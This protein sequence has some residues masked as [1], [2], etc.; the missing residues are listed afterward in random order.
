MDRSVSVS[1]WWL[2]CWLAR[3]IRAERA[4]SHVARGVTLGSRWL[5]LRGISCSLTRFLVNT[6][7]APWGW[8][9][10]SVQS[11]AG[12]SRIW[13]IKCDYSLEQVLM[14]LGPAPLVLHCTTSSAR[15][16]PQWNKQGRWKGFSASDLGTCAVCASRGLQVF[17]SGELYW[18]WKGGWGVEERCIVGWHAL[19]SSQEGY[20]LTA[21]FF[22][23]VLQTHRVSLQVATAYLRLVRPGCP[24]SAQC[25]H[26]TVVI[27]NSRSKQWLF[28]FFCFY[29]QRIV[30]GGE[31][32][33]CL[34]WM[35]EMGLRRA[36][37]VWL[38]TRDSVITV[39]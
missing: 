37:A 30:L 5:F 15:G 27:A 3:S 34:S 13:L 21:F 31:L 36:W 10:M 25:L 28:F 35:M 1:D 33:H 38:M 24:V 14:R 8:H 23:F 22:F 4:T 7:P 39:L 11:L 32:V 18:E 12:C 19:K 6:T 26:L 20:W 9:G 16:K 17:H 29:C 2:R